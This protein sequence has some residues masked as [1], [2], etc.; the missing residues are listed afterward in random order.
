[1]ASGQNYSDAPEKVSTAV[2]VQNTVSAQYFPGPFMSVFHVF[3]GLFNRVDIE[4][5][6]FSYNMLYVHGS[7]MWQ[8]FGLFSMTF[9][10]LGVIT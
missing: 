9:Q 5:V 8:S 6:R 3:P 4:E 2:R 7:E 1:M 10:N